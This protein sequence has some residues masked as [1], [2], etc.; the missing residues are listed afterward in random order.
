M[1]RIPALSILALFLLATM[2]LPGQS[3]SSTASDIPRNIKVWKVCTDKNPPPCAKPPQPI[4]SP[5][6]EY[7]KEARKAKIEGSVV[8][9]AVVGVDGHPHNI[10]VIRYLGHGLDELAIEKFRQWTFEPGTANGSPV[11]V[12]ISVQINF[13]LRSR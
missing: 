13:H 3:T 7:S 6:P 11:P 1:T 2:Q 10:Q 12:A 9:L 8:L 5:N 4:H